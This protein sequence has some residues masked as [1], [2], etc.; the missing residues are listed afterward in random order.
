MNTIAD[1]T[2][3]LAEMLGELGAIRR[4]TLLPNGET[5]SDSHHAFVLAITSMDICKKYCPE[6]DIDKVVRFALIHDLLEIITGDQDTLHLSAEE[7]EE[8]RLLEERSWDEFATRFEKY[9]YIVDMLRQ[10]ERL[11]T[12]EAATVFLLDKA[13]TTWT[14]FPDHGAYLPTRKI[15]RTEDVDMWHDKQWH[16]FLTRV[17]VH[18]PQPIIDIYHASFDKM[19]AELL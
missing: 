7:L 6:L 17:K 9:P 5:E 12:Q 1:D 8:K 16:K 13:C 2:I 3:V 4:A 14:H 18:P 10:Y 11:D 15:I 19:K